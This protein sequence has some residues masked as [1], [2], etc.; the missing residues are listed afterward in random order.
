MQIEFEV[1]VLDV[2]VDSVRARLIELGANKIGEFDSRRFV[3]DFSPVKPNSWVRLRQQCTQVQ[4]TIKEIEHDGVEGTRE[5]EVVVDDFDNMHAILQ[6]L[7]Y[8]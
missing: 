3:Y 6:K 8:Q 7:G 2:D 5:L 1:K 4:L